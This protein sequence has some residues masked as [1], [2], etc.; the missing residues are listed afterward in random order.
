VAAVTSA[1]WL[2][3]GLLLGVLLAVLLIEWHDGHQRRQRRHR[4]RA[5]D[6]PAGDPDWTAN[7]RVA[8]GDL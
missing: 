2:L 6:Q 3:V 8:E 5:A 4:T 7:R 1:G